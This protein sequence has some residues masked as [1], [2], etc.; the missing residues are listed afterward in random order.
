MIARPS[1]YSHAPHKGHI[2]QRRIIGVCVKVSR[3]DTY[4]THVVKGWA[5][6]DGNN[7]NIAI[8]THDSNDSKGPDSPIEMPSLSQTDCRLFRSNLMS[9]SAGIK[10]D[11]AIVSDIT[12]YNQR[13]ERIKKRYFGSRPLPV[14]SK[15]WDGSRGMYR[16]LCLPEHLPTGSW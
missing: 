8:S 5:I 4:K 14:K 11:S 1:Q 16:C 12:C 7:K 3:Q 9:P 10:N 6:A 15:H 13:P 2:H